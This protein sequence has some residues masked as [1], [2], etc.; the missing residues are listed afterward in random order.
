MHKDCKS[1]TKKCANER[2]HLSNTGGAVLLILDFRKLIIKTILL[3][4][5][6]LIFKLMCLIGWSSYFGLRLLLFTISIFLKINAYHKFVFTSGLSLMLG[7]HSL[8]VKYL[9]H[10]SSHLNKWPK[11]GIIERNEQTNGR[12]F[13]T[14]ISICSLER[15][16]Y[17]YLYLN[18]LTGLLVCIG[19]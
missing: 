7:A 4:F 18:G 17:L 8:L 12:I 14:E 11:R 13:I 6:F 9:N 19:T 2:F 10:V 15:F 16:T 5:F 3:I 1:I